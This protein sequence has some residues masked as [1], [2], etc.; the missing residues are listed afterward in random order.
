MRPSPDS[1]VLVVRMG[2]MGDVIHALPAVA[3]LKHSIPGSH[4]S[5]VIDPKWACLLAGNPFVDRV[6][7]LDRHSMA[8]IKSA[9]RELRAR[10]E[11]VAALS[12]VDFVVL[13]E[14]GPLEDLL[15]QLG[16]SEVLRGEASDESIARDLIRHVHKRQCAG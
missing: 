16:A 10:A 3:T 12:V 8:G 2:S 6:V 5:W 1:G 9:W 11:L 14:E 7:L 13:S 15:T 4:V